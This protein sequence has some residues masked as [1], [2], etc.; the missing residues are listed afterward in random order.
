MLRARIVAKPF[1][2][3]VK[4]EKTGLR[5]ANNENENHQNKRFSHELVENKIEFSKYLQ[6]PSNRLKSCDG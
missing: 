1:I 3:A 5:P 4:C 2:V 6:I